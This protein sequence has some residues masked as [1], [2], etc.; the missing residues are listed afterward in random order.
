MLEL[1]AAPLKLREFCDEIVEEMR[2]VNPERE[3]DYQ[4]DGPQEEVW[5]DSKLM[6]IVLTNLLSNAFKYSGSDSVVHFRVVQNGQSAVFEVRDEGI[7]IPPEDQ[8]RLF[9]AFHRAPN[10]LGVPGTGLGL[11]VVKK[12]LDVHSGT[13]TVNSEV[14]VGTRF[15]VRVPFMGRTAWRQS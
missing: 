1:N 7:G 14:G 5:I 8:P 3:L 2:S 9:E 12:S 4:N 13:V 6:R 15:E 11:A 10:T